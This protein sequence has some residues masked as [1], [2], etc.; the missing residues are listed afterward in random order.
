MIRRHE[1]GVLRAVGAR[2]SDIRRLLM[3][4]AAVVGLLAGSAGVVIALVS[5]K[6]ADHLATS[7]IPDFPFKPESLFA[8]SPLLV[9]AVV[10]VAVAACIVGVVPATA[11]AVAGDP[12]DALSGR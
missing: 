12:S 10:G 7:R 9:A 4:E 8:F 5:A 6:V 2:K 11:R 1:I 3:T